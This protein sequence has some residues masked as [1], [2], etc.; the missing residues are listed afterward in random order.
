MWVAYLVEQ[1]VG[2]MDTMLAGKKGTKLVAWMI[3]Y[4]VAK[5][6]EMKSD[7]SVNEDGNSVEK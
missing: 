4:S 5:K 7:K 3:I 2:K 1:M 6:V